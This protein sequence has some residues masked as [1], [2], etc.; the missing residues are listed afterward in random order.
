MQMS[1]KRFIAEAGH[2]MPV[3]PPEWLQGEQATADLAQEG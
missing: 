2:G 3:P 1:W